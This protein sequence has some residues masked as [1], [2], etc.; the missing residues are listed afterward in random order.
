MISLKRAD[1]K[2]LSVITFPH[3]RVIVI[4]RCDGNWGPLGVADADRCEETIASS[5]SHAVRNLPEEI[6]AFAYDKHPVPK[7]ASAGLLKQASRAG[8]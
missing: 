1:A 3:E 7:N 5:T 2:I 8:S 6:A 4:G